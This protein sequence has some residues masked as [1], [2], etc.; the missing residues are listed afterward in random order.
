MDLTYSQE[1]ETFRKQVREFLEGW[2]LKGDEAKLPQAKQESLFRAR[3]IERGF[4]YRD[5]PEKYGGS[6]QEADP[7]KNTIVLEE[8]ASVGAPGNEN[9]Q[10]PGMLAPTLIEFGNEEQKISSA[11]RPSRATSG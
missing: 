3:G 4:V 1:H 9:T 2:P 7:I 8:Y 6:G 11:R 5:I 10:G